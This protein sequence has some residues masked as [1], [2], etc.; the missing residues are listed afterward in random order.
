MFSCGYGGEVM[1][2]KVV[3]N[4]IIVPEIARLVAEGTKVTFT[5]KGI[6]MLPFIRGDRDSV[7]LVKAD[8]LRIGDIAL[9]RIGSYYVLHRIIGIDAGVVTLMGDGNIAGIEK[10]TCEDILAIA[11]TIRKD[12]REIDCR[13]NNHLRKAEIWKRMLPVRRYLLAIYRRII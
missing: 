1:Q 5:P 6:S 12:G 13:S 9:A 3:A 8:D 4:D 7:V 2:K 11:E 10:C